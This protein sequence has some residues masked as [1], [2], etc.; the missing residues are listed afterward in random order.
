MT[1]GLSREERRRRLLWD[2][3]RGRQTFVSL[4]SMARGATGGFSSGGGDN[5]IQYVVKESLA[6]GWAGEKM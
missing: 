3:P 6:A 1:G 2:L 5:I 4:F